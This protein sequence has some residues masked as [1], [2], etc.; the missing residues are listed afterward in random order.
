MST[1]MPRPAPVMNQTLLSVM[2]VNPSGQLDRGELAVEVR[3]G[4]S[5]VHEEVAA[6]DERSVAT[7][8]QCA[9]GSDFVRGAAA[10]GGGE[11]DH[12]SVPL[13]ASAGQLVRG[14]RREDDAGADRVDPGAPLA[15]ADGLGHHAEGVPALGELV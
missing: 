2:C 3:R 9:D 14:E 13:A 5:T 10:A 12:A 6:G 4:D 11:L 7:H 1:P 15:P 8:E